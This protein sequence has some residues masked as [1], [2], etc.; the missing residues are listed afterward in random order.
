[1][2]NSVAPVWDGNETW[3]VLN[4][5][6][7]YGAFSDAYG[8]LFSAWY[9]AVMLLLVAL[10]FRGVAFEFRDRARRKRPWSIA[11]SV[12]SIIAA[13]IQGALLG[14]LISGFKV[15]DNLF[16]GGAL[17]WLTP[18]SVTTGVALVAGYGLLG[19]TWLIYRTEGQLQAWSYRAARSLLLVVLGFIVAVS[20][21]T[22]LAFPHIARRWFDFHDLPWLAPLPL[23]AV[24]DV[25]A[26]YR[27]LRRRLEL[28][29]FILAVALFL[30]CFIGLVASLWPYLVPWQVSIQEAATP[31]QSQ[32]FLLIGVLLLLP[33]VLGY[34]VHAYRVFRGKVTAEEGY[35]LN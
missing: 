31:P 30:L 27:A 18:F 19:A 35:H 1:M 24:M 23:L 4:G 33:L 9:L 17:D 14:S 28:A 10:V 13:F 25:F 12:G 21:W 26:L 29:P 7:L 3:L 34:T 22:P 20:I 5:A 2:I 16:A 6:I 15:E 32:R 11:F 8:I